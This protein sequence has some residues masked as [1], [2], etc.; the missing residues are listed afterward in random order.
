MSKPIFIKTIPIKNLPDE[1]AKLGEIIGD[2]SFG[3]MN[4]ND[5]GEVINMDVRI[6]KKTTKGYVRTYNKLIEKGYKIK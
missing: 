5:E 4:H 6:I 2:C 3:D 1:M